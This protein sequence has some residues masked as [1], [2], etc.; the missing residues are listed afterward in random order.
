MSPLP[1]VIDSDGNELPP[2]LTEEE[3]KA[4]NEGIAVEIEIAMKAIARAQEIADASGVSFSWDLAYGMGGYY[5][6]TRTNSKGE[7]FNEDGRKLKDW[8]ISESTGWRSSSSEC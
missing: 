6:P 4:A 3:R 2:E 5:T 7:V 1:P 8:E